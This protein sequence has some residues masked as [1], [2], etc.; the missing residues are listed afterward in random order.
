LTNLKTT[1][2]REVQTDRKSIKPV[3]LHIRCSPQTQQLS[4]TSSWSSLW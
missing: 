2:F 4:F 3:A 1:N